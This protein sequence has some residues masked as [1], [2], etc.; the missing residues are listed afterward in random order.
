MN[1]TYQLLCFFLC[2]TSS[3]C[4][5]GCS[6]STNQA[7]P[8]A[9]EHHDHDRKLEDAHEHHRTA[10]WTDSLWEME[11]HCRTMKTAVANGQPHAAD[12]A[13]HELGYRLESMP[14]L[15]ARESLPAADQQQVKK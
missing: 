12:V 5:V 13:I 10:S 15:A 11:E 3:V 14:E 1:A 6:R 7:H 9:S 8:A 2:T 4:V